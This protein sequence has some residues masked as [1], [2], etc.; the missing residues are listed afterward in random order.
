M[1]TDKSSPVGW[2]VLLADS[3]S[4]AL[5]D[6]GRAGQP[7]PRRLASFVVSHSSEVP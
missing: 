4:P 5:T 3:L 7:A 6:G 1:R 2:E